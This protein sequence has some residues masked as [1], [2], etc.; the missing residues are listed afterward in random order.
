MDYHFHG[1]SLP[2]FLVLEITFGSTNLSVVYLKFEK[3][4]VSTKKSSIIIKEKGT[5][6]SRGYLVSKQNLQ[7]IFY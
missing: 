3:N 5:T 1:L 6:K 4:I 2:F 7:S